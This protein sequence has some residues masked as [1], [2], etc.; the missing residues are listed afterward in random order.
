MTETLRLFAHSDGPDSQQVDAAPGLE[1]PKPPKPPA[2]SEA[3]AWPAEIWILNAMTRSGSKGGW[4]SH[5]YWSSN[6][7]ALE[8]I[9][10]RPEYDWEMSVVYRLLSPGV[11]ANHNRV[12][13]GEGEGDGQPGEVEAA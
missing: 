12:Y 8:E 4:R 11:I 9:L 10:D 5:F 13:D 3:V 7:A 1:P 6:E 2:P